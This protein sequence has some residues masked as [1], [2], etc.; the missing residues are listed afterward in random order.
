M[1]EKIDYNSM[2]PDEIMGAHNETI[3]MFEDLVNKFQN[4][5]KETQEKINS[6]T[7]KDAIPKTEFVQ[8]L[9]DDIN[10]RLQI[11]SN[12]KCFD[13]IKDHILNT[14]MYTHYCNDN[15]DKIEIVSFFA[16][17]NFIYVSELVGKI[18]RV[19]LWNYDNRIVVSQ[20]NNFPGSDTSQFLPILPDELKFYAIKCSEIHGIYL[21]ERQEKEVDHLYHIRNY[22]FNKDIFLLKNNIIVHV[23]DF[24]MP[25]AESKNEEISDNIVND[26]FKELEQQGELNPE[27][28]IKLMDKKLG[29]NRKSFDDLMKSFT[30]DTNIPK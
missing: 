1:E 26:I 13:A 19:R 6:E 7:K 25:K 18:P 22:T 21:F 5:I 10:F 4:D 8:K 3:K 20:F 16:R 17:D 14:D 30:F 27:E 2:S 9:Q 12:N 15:L 11:F 24:E 28:F 23:Q 29:E